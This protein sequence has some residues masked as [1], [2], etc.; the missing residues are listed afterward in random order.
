MRTAET[1]KAPSWMLCKPL[2]LLTEH[3]RGSVSRWL[4]CSARTFFSIKLILSPHPT[5]FSCLQA[6]GLA[7]NERYRSFQYETRTMI[8]DFMF[9][10]QWVFKLCYPTSSGSHYSCTKWYTHTHTH[11]HTQ[12]QYTMFANSPQANIACFLSPVGK[13]NKLQFADMS[14]CHRA[15]RPRQTIRL[16]FEILTNMVTKIHLL[17]CDAV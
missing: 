6:R 2:P 11:T 9:G 10:W 12:C 8:Q 3:S 14:L 13:E 4:F 16:R 15:I 7:F 17:G 1:N 5:F